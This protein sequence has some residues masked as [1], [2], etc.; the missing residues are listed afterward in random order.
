MVTAAIVE[1]EVIS[2]RRL[3][4]DGAQGVAAL[5]PEGRR[6]VAVPT[7]GTGVR[8][9]VGDRVDVVPTDADGLSSGSSSSSGAV[10]T[11][12]AVVAVDDDAVTLAVDEADVPELAA[13]L[14]RGTPVLALIGPG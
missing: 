7:E 3:A 8:L 10:T 5:V 13:A 1:G 14:G 4:P 11:D 2:T 12:A 9:E 6:A